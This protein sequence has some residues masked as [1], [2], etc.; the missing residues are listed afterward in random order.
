LKQFRDRF[1]IPVADSEIEHLPLIKFAAGSEEDNYLHEARAK[2]GG[3]LPARRRQSEPLVIPPL[4][5]FEQQLQSTEGRE[6][7]TTMAFVRVL[8]HLLRDKNI[9][10]RIVP[11]VP[12][13]SRT[14][15]MEGMFRQYGIFSQ[16]GQL[17]RPQDADQ[18]SY[19]KEDRSGQML[20][21][22]INEAGAMASWIAAATSYSNSNTPMI[23]F[24]IYY[25]M[26]GFQRIHDLAWAAGDMRARGFLLGG[27]SGRTTLNG[28]GLQH[29]DGHSHIFS[30]TIPN[31]V[32]YDPTYSYEVAV[33]LQHGLERMY[34][35]K[36]EDVYYYITLLN[37]NYEHPAMPQGVEEGI[38]K[39]MYLLKSAPEG[40]P[41]EKRVKLLGSGAILREVIAGAALLERD[42]AIHADIYSVTS[43][44]ELK[45]EAD[46]VERWNL[47]H[48]MEEPRV[49]YVTQCLA[50]SG[51]APTVASTD[52]IR[53][54]AEQIR[55]FVPG[56]YK[57]LGTDG[58][59]RS[60]Y[61]RKLRSF[62]EVDRHFVAV[63]ALK[64][65]AE[66]QLLPSKKVAEAI[67]LYHLDPEKPDPMLS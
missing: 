55:A 21:E 11:I 52:Y 60:D 67:E 18:L 24:Y 6:I 56:R 20:Q 35:P 43:F 2:L 59:G 44:T 32:S 30:A 15:G 14:F 33:I 39:G 47:L 3:Y 16:V 61:R 17:Y 50:A 37:E 54:F 8:N 13:E 36:G 41:K 62:F 5:A 46:A 49:A 51:D 29:E 27:T 34:G 63:A 66:S 22:G 38:V 1:N 9:G 64:A 53:A 26:F 31:C 48:P 40:T 4:S 12:D 45:R 7:S 58:F 28:E 65:L 57:V 42:F 25:S 10:K 19:Y 23:P